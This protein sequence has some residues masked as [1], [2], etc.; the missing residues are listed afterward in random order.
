MTNLSVAAIASSLYEFEPAIVFHLRH[1]VS[2]LVSFFACALRML[3]KLQ[4]DSSQ[5]GA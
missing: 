1:L 2:L 4:T 5:D 3:S